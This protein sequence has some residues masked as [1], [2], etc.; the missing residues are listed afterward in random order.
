MTRA[1]RINAAA[2]TPPSDAPRRSGVT[3]AKG[4]RNR[5]CRVATMVFVHRS[6]QSGRSVAVSV[7][8]PSS[9]SDGA[10]SVAVR[11]TFTIPE[12]VSPRCR[13]LVREASC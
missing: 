9:C 13:R 7:R 6:A 2:L 3:A 11:T 1:L 8:P 5:R 10:G 12:V 4:M